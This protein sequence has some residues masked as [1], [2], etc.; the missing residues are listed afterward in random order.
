MIELALVLAML[1]AL[2]V[3]AIPSFSQFFENNRITTQTNNFA[4]VITEARGE[5]IKRGN[6]IVLCAGNFSAGCTGTWNDGW[7]MFEDLDEDEV[8]DDVMASANDM[9]ADGEECIVELG[10]EGVELV[11]STDLVLSFQS[12]GELVAAF[13]DLPQFCI[14]NNRALTMNA[15]GRISITNETCPTP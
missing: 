11:A 9:C 5:A 1:G 15:V 8:L 3:L 4:S 2:I 6:N 13:D 14:T 12:S 10:T 7:I